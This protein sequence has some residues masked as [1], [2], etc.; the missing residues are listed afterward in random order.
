MILKAIP[1]AVRN[2]SCD[3]VFAF[4]GNV[5]PGVYPP[6]ATNYALDLKQ[7]IVFLIN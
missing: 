3:A 1:R 7:E 2:T 4:A 5:A 6:A